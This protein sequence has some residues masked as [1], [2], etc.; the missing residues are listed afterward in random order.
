MV[1][2]LK[3]IKGTRSCLLIALLLSSAA[4]IAT[5][6]GR[7]I[8]LNQVSEENSPSICPNGYLLKGIE[9]SGRYCDNKIL[10]CQLLDQSSRTSP[11]NG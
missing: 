7:T 10:T 1:L 2:M 8:T 6:T 4:A 11:Y 3:I 9:C 5:G